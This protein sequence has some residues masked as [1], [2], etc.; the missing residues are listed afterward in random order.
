MSRSPLTTLAPVAGFTGGDAR[1]VVIAAGSQAWC[2]SAATG[3]RR[4]IADTGAVTVVAPV[5]SADT[6]LV[7]GSDGAVRRLSRSSGAT[8]G[9]YGLAFAARK[10]A[11]TAG[12]LWILDDDGGLSRVTE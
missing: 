6:I 3:G 9:S 5:L 11:R 12:R 10:L 2:I 1:E 7:G 8:L 4:W